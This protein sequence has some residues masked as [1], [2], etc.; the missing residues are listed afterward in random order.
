[1]AESRF[2]KPMVVGSTPIVRSMEKH[3]IMEDRVV[4]FRPFSIGPDVRPDYE[5]KLR[6]ERLVDVPNA[7]IEDEHGNVHD[8]DRTWTSLIEMTHDLGVE[9][10]S[11]GSDIGD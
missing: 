2:S 9:V 6:L 3:G 7:L 11:W 5:I 8:L 1:M 4:M 10:V